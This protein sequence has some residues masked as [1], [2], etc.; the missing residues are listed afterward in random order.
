MADQVRVRLTEPSHQL[1]MPGGHRK[2]G[3]GTQGEERVDPE[4]PFWSQL[5]SDGS[6][7]VVKERQVEG[8][9]QPADTKPAAEPARTVKK[10][11]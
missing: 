10:E 9:D 2:F 11:A 3:E 6:I 7:R 8:A 4:S 1:P 5:I